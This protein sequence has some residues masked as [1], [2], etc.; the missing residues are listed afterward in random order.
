M[1]ITAENIM[2]STR[3]DE[4]GEPILEYGHRFGIA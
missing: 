4:N 2:G 1:I 3:N